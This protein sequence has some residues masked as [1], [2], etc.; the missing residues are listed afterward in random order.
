MGEVYRAR[1]TKLGRDVAIKILPDAFSADP[2]RVARF[3]REAQ[4]LAALNHPNI[5]AIHGLD[6]ADGL[7]FLILELVDGEGLD[8]RLRGGALP[9]D[10][11]LPIAKQ[12]VDAVEAAHEKGIVHRD[13]K[14]AN[15]MVTAD[16]RVKVLDFGLAKQDSAASAT[17]VGPGATHSP[18]LTFAATQAG[19]I[20]GTAAYMS[21]EQAKGR[22]ADKRSDVW[23]FGCVLFEVLTGRRAFEGEDI[24][25]T[26]AAI[27]RGEPDWNA[28]PPEVP[29]HIR[30][31]VER[32]LRKDRRARIP[33]FA[34]VRYS[35][36]EPDA[37]NSP[38]IAAADTASRHADSKTALRMWQAATTLLALALAGAAVVWYGSRGSAAPVTRFSIAPPE[39]HTFDVAARAG[40]TAAISPDGSKLAF[41]ARDPSG[42]ILL[43]V[44]AIG[45]LIAQ[46]L[47]GTDDAAFP[48][49]SPDS[50]FIGYS[51]RGRLMKVAATGGPPLMLCAF[52][53][54]LFVGRGGSWNRDGVIVFNNGPGQPIFRVSSAGG[55]P[56]PAWKLPPEH[57]VQE[58][59]SFLPD[60]KRVLIRAA[61]PNSPSA[62][63]IGSLESGELN[64][65]VGAD[66]GA[67]YAAR[68]GY[69]L[70]ARQATL[71]AQP[72]DP[73]TL[74]LTGDPVPIAERVES[75]I[76]A[77][78]V[79]FSVSDAGILSYGTGSGTAPSLEMVWVDRQ[80]KVI[81]VVGSPRNYQGV[82]LSP[83][84]KRLAAHIHDGDGGDI[85][86]TELPRGTTSRYTFDASQDNSSPVW[87]PDGNAI[88]FA[89]R[90]EGR[91]WGLYKKLADNTGGD[92]LLFESD[93]PKRP[94]SWSP[95]GRTIVFMNLDP[96][97]G[98]DL[99]TLSLSN[100]RRPTPWAQMPFTE[101]QGVVSPDGRWLAY[102]S[103]ETGLYE[104]YVRP[105]PSGAGK[106][107]VSR[108]GG[109]FPIWRGDG[110]ELFHTIRLG[111]SIVAVNVAT[112]AASFEIGTAQILFDERTRLAIPGEGGGHPY[113]NYAVS[114]DGQRVLLPRAA[115]RDGDN[116]PAAI[117]VVI[118]WT[119][120]IKK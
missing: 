75:G 55:S 71:L 6:D 21:P 38:R 111:R 64:R 88:V 35:L 22:A 24:S 52:N 97:T 26:L 34:V 104:V 101:N 96:K 36:E 19:V 91:K 66:T 80:G 85:W 95:D 18:T 114:P 5:A 83:D 57:T 2:D 20:L 108:D 69:L 7:R 60:G 16:G 14:P 77:G 87:S 10:E 118:N 59:P 39:Q 67:V 102:F 31:I 105:F 37:G 41:S 42:K 12:I 50:R 51:R 110:R 30:R 17:S 29:P 33:D 117:A 28:V 53:D 9:L 74:A 45:S 72:F 109:A 119:T 48:F 13:L 93:T 43:W 113:S 61:G 44:R 62:V 54:Q 115:A 68:Y 47:P 63:Y 32:C 94:V 98:Q 8:V 27:L 25:D 92:E 100:D 70:F 40:A 65:L 84:G 112:G 86:V 99:W 81:E 82:A 107:Q 106:W 90:R 3:Q 58:F 23:S 116:T 4:A 78:L 89:S 1:D 11:A 15:I 49:W 120:E 73:R 56:S 103:N 76:I 46:P 79:S